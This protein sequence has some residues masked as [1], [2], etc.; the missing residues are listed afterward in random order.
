[1]ATA[2]AAV[3]ATTLPAMAQPSTP[4]L[5]HHVLFWLANPASAADKARLLEGLRSL[6][7]IESL[8][9]FRIGTPAATEKRPVID[10]SYAFSLFTA[11]DD[12]KGHD[13]YQVHP[14]HL[15]FIE[16][17]KHLWGRV[18]IY[19]AQQVV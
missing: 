11:F 2:T 3:A 6:Q 4:K 7:S 17:Y 16:T 9:D 1:M 12:V 8:R 13:A 5:I 18:L 19:D 14:I 10:D 15:K